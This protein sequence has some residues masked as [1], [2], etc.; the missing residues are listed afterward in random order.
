M[1]VLTVTKALVGALGNPPLGSISTLITPLTVRIMLMVSKEHYI[2]QHATVHDV[3]TSY[4]RSVHGHDTSEAEHLVSVT[5]GPLSRMSHICGCASFLF[6]PI[7]QSATN[8]DR[9]RIHIAYLGVDWTCYGP[10]VALHHAFWN[11]MVAAEEH[12]YFDQSESEP[13]RHKPPENAV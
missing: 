2:V 13:C 10:I 3:T 8:F 9:G 4:M 6:R 7:Y 11:P 12:V 1:K 5:W